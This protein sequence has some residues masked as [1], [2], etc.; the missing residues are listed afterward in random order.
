MKSLYYLENARTSEQR[1]E[2][3]RLEAEGKCL[4]CP[5]YLE[6]QSGQRVL[7]NGK[8]ELYRE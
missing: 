6:T 2:M 5:A 3:R 8:L 7:M 4:F 1:D